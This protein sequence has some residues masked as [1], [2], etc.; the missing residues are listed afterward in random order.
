MY[1]RMMIGQGAVLF[2]KLYLIIVFYN[3]FLFNF[4]REINSTLLVFTV[5]FFSIP[6]KTEL[7]VGETSAFLTYVKSSAPS[8]TA[9]IGLDMNSA[10]SK[11]MNREESSLVVSDTERCN[12]KLILDGNAGG[13][14]I[15][16]NDKE[17][18]VKDFQT[19]QYSALCLSSSSEQPQN[20]VPLDVSA[21]PPFFSPFYYPRGMIDQ[22]T[23]SSAGQ[24]FQGSLNDVHAQALLPH[25]G[26]V[27]HVPLMPTFHYQTLGVNLQS[28]HVATPSVSSS[29]TSPPDPETKYGR[30]EKRQAALVKFRQKRKARCFDKKIRYINRKRL[31]EKRPRVRGQFVKQA[32]SVDLNQNIFGGANED[33]ED[34]E[35]DEPTSKELEL[36]SSPE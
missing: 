3:C 10:P 23:I 11:S 17:C 13:N 32:S 27:P 1:Q 5:G 14:G 24:I 28:G 31:A 35:D 21:A 36:I 6:K 8:R 25:Y 26:V 2:V 20:E 22:N 34:E 19:P 12:R 9:L 30:T 18:H 33:S 15:I 7:K 29:M 4:P 16:T